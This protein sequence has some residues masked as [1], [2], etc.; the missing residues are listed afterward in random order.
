MADQ[1]VGTILRQT[2]E[3]KKLTLDQVFQA[4]HIRLP[5]LQAIENDALDKIPSRAQA[6]GFIRLYAEYLELDSYKLLEP[7]Q[8]APA[9]EEKISEPTPTQEEEPVVKAKLETAVQ[10]S[11]DS[12]N[13]KIKEGAEHLQGTWQGLTDKL[14]YRIV[15]KAEIAKPVSADQEENSEPILQ[16]IRANPEQLSYKAMCKALGFRLRQKR[17][18]LG[19]SLSDIERQ[20]RIR[21]IYLY[22]LEEGDLNDLPSTVQGRGMLGNYATFLGLD[23]ESFL[24]SFAEALQQKRLET[25]PAEKEGVPLPTTVSKQSLT[26]WRRLLSPDLIFT[27]GLFLVFFVF[28]L[29]GSVQM[30]GIRSNTTL[31]T[32][33]PISDLLLAS[34]TP[35]S[36]DLVT[37][38]GAT[39]YASQN[40]VAG[41]TPID[42]LQET[43]AATNSGAIQ[44]VVVAHKR[45][46]MKITVDGKV[47]FENRVT[48]GTIYAYSGNISIELLTGDGSALEVYYNQTDQGLL[49]TSGQVMNLQ[50]TTKGTVDLGAQNTATPAPS[51]IPSLTPRPTNIPTITPN[52]PTPTITDTPESTPGQ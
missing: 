47:T 28:I 43:L 33:I 18:S 19:L 29:W 8:P 51:V 22:A 36:S 26:G 41:F 30:V 12:I 24:S 42:N 5:Y 16:P 45:A 38:E 50:F 49:G 32:V 23:S 15:K 35:V 14:P 27:G 25:L 2:R 21:E 6:R 39:P 44:V 48:P 37:I 34:G 40:A 10:K 7:A 13:E 11:K 17:E 4:T 52:Q 20:T 3:S 9:V 31:P 1:S 46:Y